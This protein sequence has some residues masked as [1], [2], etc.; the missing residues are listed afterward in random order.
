MKA[1]HKSK[2]LFLITK[3]SW[4]GAQRYVFDLATNIDKE[5]FEPVIA[6]GG[7][8]ELYEKLRAAGLHTISIKGLG[9]DVSVLKDLQATLHILSI[10]IKE[11]PAV[12]HVNSS[13]V[14][15]LG[16]LA[17]R[18]LFIPK[19]I[20]TC[21]GWAFNEDRPGWQKTILKF[22]QWLTVLFSHTT[23]VVS[24]GVKKDMN[25]L[26]TKKKMQVVPL[27][28]TV[29]NLKSREDARGI[30]AMQVKDNTISLY[31]H[32]DDIWL[33][34]IAE[35]HP[36]KGL[37]VAINAIALLS[38]HTQNL[39]YL[40]IHDGDERARLAKLVKDLGL[41]E[42][43]FFTGT[44]EN[45]ATLLPAFDIFLLPSRSE[46]F[47][48]VLIEAGQAGIPVIAS[49]VGGIPEVVLDQETGILVPPNEA[50]ALAGA[51]KA[52]LNDP[53]RREEFAAAHHERSLTFSLQN[54]VKK[55]EKLYE[56]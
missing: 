17:G 42:N 51:V 38:H 33:G 7:T 49:R 31:D 41:E 40:I 44:I 34:T 29:A 15:V 25:W 45:A 16:T 55:T 11:R 47:G 24:E 35:L 6:V 46:A 37:D 27:G 23:I 50:E 13:K 52:L 54:M 10:I 8:G 30:L 2:I 53:A 32:T 14:G 12:L 56:N 5:R 26:F 4:G 9:R 3:A 20:F 22:L 19:V 48:Y 21:H 1:S 18:L 39:R 28:R 36:T 43:V